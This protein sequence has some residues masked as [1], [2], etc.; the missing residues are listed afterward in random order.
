MKIYFIRHAEAQH[1]VDYRLYGEDAYSFPHNKF[2]LLTTDGILSAIDLS[3]SEIA[4]DLVIT[5]SL[6]RTL[7]TTQ[8]VFGVNNIPIIVSDL[9]R[10]TNFHH[11]CNERRTISEIRMCYPKFNVEYLVGEE[12]TVFHSGAD[13][14]LGRCQ[15]LNSW[16]FNLDKQGYKSIAIVTHQTFLDKYLEHCQLDKVNLDNCGVWVCDSTKVIK[17]GLLSLSTTLSR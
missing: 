13:N 12:D 9:V 15:A 16:I 11:R 10:E 5:S 3:G 1:N 7:L 2:S 8:I 14:I 17:D 6:P 4:V